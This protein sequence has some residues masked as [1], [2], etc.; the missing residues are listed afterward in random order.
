M[1]EAT[2]SPPTLALRKVCEAICQLPFRSTHRG[3]RL[4][5]SGRSKL[6]PGGGVG[7]SVGVGVRVAT[8]TC[9]SRVPLSVAV[10]IKV[11]HQTGDGVEH[12]AQAIFDVPRV[13]GCNR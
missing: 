4:V 11:G 6:S 8:T 5:E 3:P 7:V 10:V 9:T 1:Y 13:V 12:D 2:R